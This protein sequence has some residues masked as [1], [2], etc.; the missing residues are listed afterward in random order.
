M[1]TL[2]E[3]VIVKA[4][5]ALEGLVTNPPADLKALWRIGINVFVET[6]GSHRSVS[7]AAGSEARTSSEVR[8]LWTSF[9]QKWIGHIASR[10][11]APS[12]PAAPRR[13]RCR[14]QSLAT[15]LNLLNE[16]AMLATLFA[17]DQPSV[18]RDRVV[19]TLVHIWV[20]SIY[21]ES[22]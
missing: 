16:R 22:S 6:F 21:G 13:R 1:L 8:K 17:D 10:Y 12:A 15:S 20:T 7:L 5:S 2:F 19:D 14:P 4:D 3:R 9:M 18:P 11:R